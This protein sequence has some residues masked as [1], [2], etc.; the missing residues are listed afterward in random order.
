MSV[1]KREERYYVFK[2]KNLSP[3]DDQELYNFRQALGEHDD[4]GECVVVEHDW[5][6]YD[7]TWEMVKRVS[8]GTFENPYT[9]VDD[10]RVENDRLKKQFEAAESRNVELH[11]RIQRAEAA[12]SRDDN[13]RGTEPQRKSTD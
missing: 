4:I 11:S 13:A 5:P 9:E 7:A 12:L 1:F 2:I 10:L 8:E 6:C 3:E